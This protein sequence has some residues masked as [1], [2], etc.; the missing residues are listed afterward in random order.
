MALKWF[1]I[2]IVVSHL[3]TVYLHSN[4]VYKPTEFPYSRC[5]G[6]D[7]NRVT[8]EKLNITKERQ[9]K[10]S[11]WPPGPYAVPMSKYGCPES[12]TRGW[13]KSF[14][15]GNMTGLSN[16]SESNFEVSD[17]FKSPFRTKTFSLYFCVKFR[18]DSTLDTEQWIP[19]NYSI[20]K[21]GPSCPQEFE[22]ANRT[23]PVTNVVLSGHVPNVAVQEGQSEEFTNISTCIRNIV[24]TTEGIQ[25]NVTFK[26]LETDF[27]LEKDPEANCS[28][29]N[30]STVIQGQTHCFYNP[31]VQQFNYGQATELILQQQDLSK[32]HQETDFELFFID[33]QHSFEVVMIEVTASSLENKGNKYFKCFVSDEPWNLQE[34]L[35]CNIENGTL[36]GI[37]YLR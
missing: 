8:C 10:Q 18:N 37:I 31:K 17:Y 32:F 2:S 27:I 12:H 19:G 4:I 15:K 26:M 28:Q 7:E 24:N 1:I 34:S 16:D 25:L 9:D 20:Y 36:P 35:L 30:V 3:S 11:K 6:N 14:M 22:D 13:F 5:Y 33:C 23:L 29:F 21:I